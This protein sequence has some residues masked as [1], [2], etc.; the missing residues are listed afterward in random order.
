MAIRRGGKKERAAKLIE[1]AAAVKAAQTAVEIAGGKQGRRGRPRKSKRGKGGFGRKLLLTGLVIGAAAAINALIFYRTPPLTS[2][3][4]G[5]TLYY[6]TP[7]GDVFYKKAGTGSPLLLVHGIGAGCSSAEWAKVWDDLSRRHTVYA[8]DLL[9][10]G[11]SDKPNVDYTDATYIKL[12]AD[13]A[14]DVMGVGGD[15]GEAD[16][17][18]SSLSGAYAIAL[19][20]MD[21]SLFRRLVLVCPTGIDEL[22]KTPGV[23]S[24]VAK[25][26]LGLPVLGTSLYNLMTSRASVRRYLQRYIYADPAKVTDAIVTQYHTSAHQ[27]GGERVLPG[28]VSGF[29]N[30]AVGEAFRGIEELPLLVWGQQAVQTPV[31]QAEPFLQLNPHAKLEVIDGAGL[32]PHDEQPEAFLAAVRP[33]L[34]EVEESPRRR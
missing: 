30:I 25:T 33:F 3:L 2:A 9:G 1:A 32:L 28:F 16:V 26:L 6:Q 18:A 4:D 15:R 17:I 29:L 11:K 22:A 23:G 27:P 24:T 14:R 12:L 7:D 31:G 5:D 19:S 21:P 34:Q 8:L 20:R 13:F 10:F